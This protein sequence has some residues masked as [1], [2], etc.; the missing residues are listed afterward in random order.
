M[1]AV[2]A[3]R[4]PLG[5]AIV[6][7]VAS[8]V[9]LL[10]MFALLAFTVLLSLN[11]FQSGEQ[12]APLFIAFLVLGVIGLLAHFVI[13]VM[14]SRRFRTATT[15]GLTLLSM[16]GAFGVVCVLSMVIGAAAG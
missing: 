5:I 14:L 11:G 7:A 16:I 2:T 15:L 10:G 1:N 6:F 4:T 12:F 9:L 8:S 3:N 13:V